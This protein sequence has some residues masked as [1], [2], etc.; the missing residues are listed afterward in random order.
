MGDLPVSIKGDLT[1]A[2]WKDKQ[3]IY[4]LTNM[5]SPPGEGNFSDKHDNATKP[6]TI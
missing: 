5:H 2:V 6:T 3:E 1:A 4:M